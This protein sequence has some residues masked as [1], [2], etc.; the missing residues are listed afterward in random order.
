[1]KVKYTDHYGIEREVDFDAA[2]N[3]MDDEIRE[4][5]NFLETKNEQDYMNEYCA[6]HQNKYHETFEVI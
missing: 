4:E 5:V 3:M 1:M 2:V 6:R